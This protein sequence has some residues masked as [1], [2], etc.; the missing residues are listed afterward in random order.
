MEVEFLKSVIIGGVVYTK[1][2]VLNVEDSAAERL[3]NRKAVKAVGEIKETPI[4]TENNT[5]IAETAVEEETKAESADIKILP[6]DVDDSTWRRIKAAIEKSLET[7]EYAVANF[8]NAEFL[9]EYGKKYGIT[10][11]FEQK[12]ELFNAIVEA[13][14]NGS[15]R[16]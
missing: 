3:I 6:A 15:R 4:V 16:D 9:A 7:G 11:R 12:Q 5:E 14:K 10:E 2:A 1:G 8:L 13:V